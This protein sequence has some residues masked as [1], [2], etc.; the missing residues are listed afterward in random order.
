MTL[1]SH[2]ARFSPAVLVCAAAAPLRAQQLIGYVNTP[3]RRD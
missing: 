1:Q 2:H 3:R